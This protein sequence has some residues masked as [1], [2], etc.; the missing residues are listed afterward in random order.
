MGRGSKN[1]NLE[2]TP[3]KMRVPVFVFVNFAKLPTVD[4]LISKVKFEKVAE[5]AF[6]FAIF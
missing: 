5:V 3:E 1:L 6:C 2:K 4:S